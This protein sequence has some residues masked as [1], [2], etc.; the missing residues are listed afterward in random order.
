MKRILFTLGLVAFL[1]TSCNQ[2]DEWLTGQEP[3]PSDIS[4]VILP[5]CGSQLT[6]MYQTIYCRQVPREI[7]VYRYRFIVKNAVT[8]A[9]VGTVDKPVNNFNFVELG[10]NN[11]ALATAY[12]V[13]V[14]VALNSSL[15]FTSVI[16]PNCTLI[17]PTLPNKS[18]VISP[19]CGGEINSLWRVVYALQSLGAEKY[20]FVIRNGGQTREIETTQSSFQLSDLPGGPAANTEYIIRVDVLYQGAWYPGDETCSI[21]T[22]ATASLRQSSISANGGNK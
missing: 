7:P 17:T 3:L 9:L 5:S 6:D 19:N 11:V 2:I 10:L 15:N 8:N 18:K 1:F 14:Q 13:E 20:K 4:F 16:N 12:K 21:F 22:S